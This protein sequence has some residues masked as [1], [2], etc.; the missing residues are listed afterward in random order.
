MVDTFDDIKLTILGPVL[1]N[2]PERRPDTTDTPGHVLD[3]GNEETLFIILLAADTNRVS[4]WTIVLQDSSVIDAQVDTTARS[5][6]DKPG[7]FC[8]TLVKVGDKAV[9]RISL[10]REIKVIKETLPL[11]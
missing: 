8:A 11:P 4:A 7:G 5:D 3:I 2:S 6:V 9:S 1:A 10:R